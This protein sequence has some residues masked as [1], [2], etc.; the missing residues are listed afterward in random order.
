MARES[1]SVCRDGF[2]MYNAQCVSFLPTGTS[3]NSRQSKLFACRD[4]PSC[5][6]A[7][8]QYFSVRAASVAYS[9]VQS[10][11]EYY[12]EFI[13]FADFDET[14]FAANTTLTQQQFADDEAFQ[15]LIQE[16]LVSIDREVS[17]H[18]QFVFYASA[19][20]CHSCHSGV[21]HCRAC[22]NRTTCARCLDR[23][24]LDADRRCVP[25]PPNSVGCRR[26]ARAGRVV[27]W[28][29]KSGY[30]RSRKLGKCVQ[31]RPHCVS[32]NELGCLE[33]S[34][35]YRLD[36]LKKRCLV[37][38]SNCVECADESTCLRCADA[39]YFDYSATKSESAL[40]ASNS[41]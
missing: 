14:L 35:F 26:D 20:T 41:R 19:D 36:R 13:R 29:C 22:A 3:L 32:Q 6:C 40:P 11:F 5:A 34:L 38:G 24:F 31:N 8:S 2:L 33:C 28:R 17:V 9:K 27:I 25:C 12:L 10:L 7:D 21:R 4:S 23:Y 18:G 1:C 37:C 15:A 16:K 30:H 39:H